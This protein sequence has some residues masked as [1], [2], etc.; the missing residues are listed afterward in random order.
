MSVPD[1]DVG[2]SPWFF[3]VHLHWMS[4][5]FPESQ[6]VRECL[7]SAWMAL[8]DWASEV[9]L[10]A[11]STLAKPWGKMGHVFIGVDLSWQRAAGITAHNLCYPPSTDWEC[12]GSWLDDRWFQSPALMGLTVAH[13]IMHQMGLN[14]EQMAL[15]DAERVDLIRS[16]SRQAFAWAGE[17]PARRPDITDW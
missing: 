5:R 6:H 11:G 12:R 15:P 16:G 8:G 17:A 7:H 9:R 4:N 2:H 1:L 13:E 10:T 14:H 3:P